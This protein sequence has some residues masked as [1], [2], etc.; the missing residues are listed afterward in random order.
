[1]KRIYFIVMLLMLAIPSISA[2]Q[3]VPSNIGIV[4]MHGKGG[5]PT[6]HV[7][8]L[9]TS[10][11]SKGY[12]VANIEMP[13]SKNREYDVDVESAYKEVESALN[14]LRSKGAQKL[15]ISGHSQGGLFALS[16]GSRVMCDGIIA[17]APGGNVGAQFYKEKVAESVNEALKLIEQGKGNEK[18]TLY[19]FE[20]SKGKYAIVTT[21]M[22][23]FSWFDPNGAMNQEKMSKKINPNIPIL[24]IAPTND[25]PG[26]LKVK[27]MMF[28]TLPKNPKTKLY[29]P[30]T[31]HLGAPSASIEEIMQWTISVA[32]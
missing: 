5:M 16:A 9:A 17:I 13:W 14:G 22:A 30:S 6:K 32:N 2:E 10:L 12:L 11:E 4:V 3:I 26:L 31:N 21:P 27:Q 20:S 25:Y 23:Y 18:T 28:D 15:F 7:L 8:D 1:M 24:F 29:E 19:D